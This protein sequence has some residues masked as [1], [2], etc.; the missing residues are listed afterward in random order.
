MGPGT[1][2]SCNSQHGVTGHR[3]ELNFAQI[4]QPWLQATGNPDDI[5]PAL[6]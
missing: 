5:L 3:S 4:L 6:F 2:A 1:E